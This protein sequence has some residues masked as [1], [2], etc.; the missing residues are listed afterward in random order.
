LGTKIE[1]LSSNNSIGFKNLVSLNNDIINND[2]KIS[3]TQSSIQINLPKF[4]KNEYNSKKNIY[5][6]NKIN[7]TEFKSKNNRINDNIFKKV[8]LIDDNI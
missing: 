6:Q 3:L 8:S 2:N 4:L 5:N 1:T 7:L